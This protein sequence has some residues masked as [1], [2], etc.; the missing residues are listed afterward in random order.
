MHQRTSSAF[1]RFPLFAVI[2]VVAGLAVWK[3]KSHT[4]PESTPAPL[5]EAVTYPGLDLDDPAPSFQALLHAAQT[6]GNPSTRQMA[7]VWLDDVARTDQ[8]LSNEREEWILEMLSKNGHHAWDEEYRLWLFNSAFNVLQASSDQDAFNRQLLQLARHDTHRTMRLYA[9]QHIG[10]QRSAGRIEGALAEETHAALLDIVSGADREVSGTAIALLTVWNGKD[11][12]A[13]PDIYAKAVA[14]AADANQPIDV[15]V[16]ALHAA[17]G[18]AL[19]LARQLATD[20]AQPVMLRKASI[21]LIGQH[22]GDTDYPALEKI[23]AENSRLAQATQP[24]LRTLRHRIANPNSAAP[25][26]F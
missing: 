23:T 22:G 14:M 3:W 2:A 19:T 24:A 1:R 6:G 25:I 15:R 12:P 7:I 9:L 10:A 13:E 5:V 17:G 16:T 8:P 21:A 26:P 4:P 20:T 18:H 11:Q